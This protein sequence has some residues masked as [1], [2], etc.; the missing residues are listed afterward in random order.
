VHIR[1]LTPADLDAAMAAT[2]HVGWGNLRPHFAFYLERSECCPL[3]AEENG[4]IVGT[5][6]GTRR[7]KV[8]WIGHVI[9]RP[10]CRRRGI[11][12]ALVEAVGA[13]LEEAG[14][15]TLL[16]VATDLGRPVYERLGFR[17]DSLY[18][19]LSGPA[20]DTFPARPNLRPVAEP[21][22][23]AIRAL[24]YLASGEDRSAHIRLATEGG[25][26]AAGATPG[27]VRGFYL[28]APWAEGPLVA[29]DPEAMALLLDV[30]R[31]TANLAR[32]QAEA[33]FTIPA[34]NTAAITHLRA[35]GFVEAAPLPRMIRGEPLDWR[36]DLI[37]GRFSG[38][39]G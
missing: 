31:A 1:P 13:R 6:A 37:G 8:G 38:A 19:K 12:S 20:L 25:W 21:D 30:T 28:P 34:A 14:C 10:D 33:R 11:G 39:I 26:V 23:P 3:V 4:Q 22:L 27:E 18:S 29:S 36:P 7:G 32:G 35:C 17:V 5:A 15:R 9:V 2:A 16:L 24:D